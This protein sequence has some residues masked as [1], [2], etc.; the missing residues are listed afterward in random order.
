MMMIEIQ[1]IDDI[2][3]PILFCDVCGGRIAEAG[4]AA[5]VFNNFRTNGERTE[6][7]YVHKGSIDGKTCHRDAEQII[8]SAGGTPGW[9]GLQDVFVDL[10]HNIAFPPALMADYDE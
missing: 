1:V 3:A 4:K 7:L 2:S 6:I 10:A 9:Q 5:I 8:R